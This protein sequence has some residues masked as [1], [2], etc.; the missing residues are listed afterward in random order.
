MC[1]IHFYLTCSLLWWTDHS[2]AFLLVWKCKSLKELKKTNPKTKQS[3]YVFK[4]ENLIKFSI[5]QLENKPIILIFE[6]KLG[7]EMLRL[8]KKNTYKGS[9]FWE[10]CLFW[11]TFIFVV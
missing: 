2:I 11:V 4:Q 1:D 9:S 3:V 8:Y 10:K 6:H 7:K 5:K